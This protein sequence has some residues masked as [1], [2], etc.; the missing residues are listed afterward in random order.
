MSQSGVWSGFTGVPQF[1][2]PS[3]KVV[4]KKLRDAKYDEK[5]DRGFLEKWRPDFPWLD[6][7]YID[8]FMFCRICRQH[9]DLA[10]SASPYVHKDGCT[11]F[12]LKSIRG[13]E[14]SK[15]H[16][17]VQ[18]RDRTVQESKRSKLATEMGVNEPVAQQPESDRALGMLTANVANRVGN[19]IKTAH[20]IA[21]NA[22]PYT[23][24]VWMCELDR[25][26]GL[27]IGSTYQTDKYC[28]IFQ[29][30]IA[31]VERK[32]L[33]ERVARSKF[34]SVMIDG[35]TDTSVQEQEIIYIRTVE[36][37]VPRMEFVSVESC[38]KS[39]AP[40]ILKAIENAMETEIQDRDWKS[41]LVGLT[42][43]GAA[44]MVGKNAGLAALLKR[45]RPQLVALHCVS[46]RLELAVKS[47]A[48]AV[49][50]YKKVDLLILNLYLFYHNSALNRSNLRRSCNAADV[51]FLVPTRVGGTRWVSH[52]LTAITKLLRIYPGLVLH[53]DQ[54]SIFHCK[55]T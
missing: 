39:D 36:S 11:N 41:K 6:Y 16:I 7:N 46:H 22:R 17:K 29:E 9:T 45:E 33:A 12:T 55:M 40:S 8:K 20:A 42:T 19:L 1:N 53:L 13:H 14:S 25:S 18:N 43:D 44:V 52:T 54:V 50:W 34:I 35:S 49:P 4:S 21:R 38:E 2:S 28:K 3:Q 15:F 31:E 10:D 26:K 30:S 24:F 47:V 48:K 5:R 32:L 37:G 51:P 23:D 27:D